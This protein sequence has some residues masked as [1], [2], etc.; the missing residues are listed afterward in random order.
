MKSV[1]YLA[2]GL[3]SGAAG[4]AFIILCAFAIIKL[5]RRRLR[6]ANRSWYAYK[7]PKEKAWFSQKAKQDV[8]MY[9][10]KSELAK[11]DAKWFAAKA[12]EAES[13]FSEAKES[14]ERKLVLVDE[15]SQEQLVTD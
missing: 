8:E 5:R 15:E 4:I 1:A 9:S 11:R 3:V 14:G 12:K 2:I 6:P 10:M 7:T 13:W